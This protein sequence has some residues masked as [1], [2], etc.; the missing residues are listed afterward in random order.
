MT[1]LYIQEATLLRN[2]SVCGLSIVHIGD[3]I[4]VKQ[5]SLDALRPPAVQDPINKTKK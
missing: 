5:Y 1:T 3:H 2:I 4:S